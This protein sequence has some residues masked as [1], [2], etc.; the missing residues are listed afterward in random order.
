MNEA[1]IA[2]CGFV[3]S[4]R[5]PS[6]VLELVEASLDAVAQGVDVTIDRDLNLA[7][8]AGRNDARSAPFPQRFANMIGII[9]AIGKQDFGFRS[10][11]FHQ[12][13]KA[14]IIRDLAGGDLGGYWQAFAIRAE[15]NLRRE[16]TSRA[17]KTLTRSPPLAPAAQ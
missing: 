5:E 17:P 6:R 10:L 4:G 13:I 12:R 1:E 11:R 2:R 9:A 15:V 16:A 14:R 3:I 8:P 7:A